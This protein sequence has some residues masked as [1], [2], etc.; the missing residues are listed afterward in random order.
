MPQPRHLVVASDFGP[1]SDRALE[2]AASLAHQ[3]GAR[4]TLLHVVEP[5]PVVSAWGDPGAAAWIGM[6]SL[7]EAG[8]AALK[9]QLGRHAGTPAGDAQPVCRIGLPRRD[10]GAIA[11]E[12]G[13]DLLVVGARNERR[14][15]DRLLGSTAQ[16]ALHHAGLPVLVARRPAGAPWSRM[17]AASDGSPAASAAI[18]WAEALAPWAEGRLLRVHPPLPEA[19]LALM[20]P[21]PARLEDYLRRE[22]QEAAARAA[23][24][25]KAHPQWQ[26]A[27]RRGAIIDTVLGEIAERAVDL[28][29]LGTRGHGPWLGGLLGSLS[30]AVLAHADTD[31]LLV[32]R[33]AE[34]RH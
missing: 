28:V 3:H 22:E 10:L 15:G 6:E 19:T 17:L 27:F 4:L 5:L 11:R 29:A 26:A 30:Q 25:A 12:L 2:R 32:P 14:L 8:D 31:V 21:D 33:P 7:L 34:P 18:D 16:A 1:A 23:D 24:E 9:R 20:Q 13:G